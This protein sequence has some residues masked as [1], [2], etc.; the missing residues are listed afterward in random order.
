MNGIYVLSVKIAFFKK[1]T[2]QQLF[3]GR[4]RPHHLQR[5]VP[6]DVRPQPQADREG[7]DL[8]GVQGRGGRHLQGRLGGPAGL[9]AQR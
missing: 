4:H 2:F 9:S 1:K 6:E 7:D 8:R 3:P 5:G